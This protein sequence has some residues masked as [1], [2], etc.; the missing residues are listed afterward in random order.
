MTTDF[1]PFSARL[2]FNA[3]DSKT[4]FIVLQRDN[5]SSLTENNYSIK[6]PVTFSQDE[7]ITVKVFFNSSKLDPDFLFGKVYPVGRLVP[8]TQAVARAAVEE[9]LKGPD[10]K[11]KAEGY[12]SSINMGVKIKKLTIE[13]GVA[14]VDFDKQIEYQLGGSAKVSAIRA[15]ITETLKQFPSV[16]EVI[17]SVEGRVDDA[18]QP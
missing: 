14:R 10:G 17:I 5:P 3:G 18:L 7:M 16:K 8:R 4:G 15:Q 9:L 13:N 1:V 2:K 12:F 11:E 6:V